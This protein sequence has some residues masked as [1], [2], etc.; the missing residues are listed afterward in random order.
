[1]GEASL[2]QHE[3][4]A[5]ASLA[6]SDP[7]AFEALRQT[8]IERFIAQAPEERRQRLRCLQW[9]IE[10]ERARCKTPFSACI[11]ISR[12]MWDKAL[13]RGGLMEQLRTLGDT[14]PAPVRSAKIIPFPGTHR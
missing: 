8:L 12:M 13:A 10:Q 9:R 5:W 7:A 3:F 2:I 14:H 4:D 11:S 1:M 6:H